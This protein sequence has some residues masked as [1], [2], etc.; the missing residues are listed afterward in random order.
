MATPYTGTIIAALGSSN[1]ARKMF[2]YTS[3]DV[4]GEFWLAP[5]GASDLV[6]NGTTDV[7][8]IDVLPSSSAGTTKNLE[9]FISGTST[10]VIQPLA[11]LV[12]TIYNRPFN[13]A[14]MRIP[15]GQM[16]KVVQ[17]A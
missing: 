1:G 9:L 15:A 16:F 17:R 2:Y 13:I 7:W 14:P 4:A 11:N 5:S 12:G 3:S 6:L 8:I 10:G